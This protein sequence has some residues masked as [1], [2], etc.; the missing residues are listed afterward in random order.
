MA[1]ERCRCPTGGKLCIEE[2]EVPGMHNGEEGLHF[3]AG[4][5]ASTGAPTVVVLS[6]F[7]RCG[8]W[9][10]TCW[11]QSEGSPLMS[12]VPRNPSFH[13]SWNF[14]I[15]LIIL[16]YYTTFENLSDLTTNRRAPR[17]PLW[18]TAVAGPTAVAHGSWANARGPPRVW[19]P[20]VVARGGWGLFV[21]RYG[22]RLNRRGP[23]R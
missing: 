18:A 5:A 10:T 2:R 3:A 16:Q 20:T 9:C 17:R 14:F 4:D 19:R 7:W 22:G 12:F 13:T 15:F 23:R 6:P 11:R 1:R 21:V 8:R